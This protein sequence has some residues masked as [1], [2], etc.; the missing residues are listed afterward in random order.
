MSAPSFPREMLFPPRSMKTVGTPRELLNLSERRPGGVQNSFTVR[1]KLRERSERAAAKPLRKS[2]EA[3]D[4][5]G[6]GEISSA[7]CV[8]NFTMLQKWAR[9]I[10]KAGTRRPLRSNL[11]NKSHP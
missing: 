2:V 9:L 10:Q 11:L 7:A 4:D 5:A 6:G 8:I 1:E 3:E